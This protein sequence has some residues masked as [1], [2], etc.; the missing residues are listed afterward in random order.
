MRK[1]KGLKKGRAV[2]RTTFR[3]L[4]DLRKQAVRKAMKRRRKQRHPATSLSAETP[5]AK[6]EIALQEGRLAKWTFAARQTG[7]LTKEDR[8]DPSVRKC[9]KLAVQPEKQA[10]TAPQNTAHAD[11]SYASRQCS[12]SFWTFTRSRLEQSPQR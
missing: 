8:Q 12:D 2:K 5:G 1:D 10:K 6:A 4:N 9:L 3:A 7:A 11:G